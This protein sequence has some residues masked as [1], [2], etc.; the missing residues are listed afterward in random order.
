MYL[1]AENKIEAEMDIGIMID[2]EA[3]KRTLVS[4]LKYLGVIVYNYSNPALYYFLVTDYRNPNFLLKL[5]S[6]FSPSVKDQVILN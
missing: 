1:A 6:K 3:R 2:L 4:I 5:T